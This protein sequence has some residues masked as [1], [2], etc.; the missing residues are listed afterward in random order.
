MATESLP[1]WASQPKRKIGG[2]SEE[3]P[4]IYVANG[5]ALAFRRRVEAGLRPDPAPRRN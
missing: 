5:K 2:P 3:G 4:P 1:P